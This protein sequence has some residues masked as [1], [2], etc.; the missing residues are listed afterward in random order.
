MDVNSLQPQYLFFSTEDPSKKPDGSNSVEYTLQPPQHSPSALHFVKELHLTYRT[1]DEPT[2]FFKRLE[3]VVVS[4][5]DRVLHRLSSSVWSTSI[6]LQQKNLMKNRKESQ[7]FLPLFSQGLIHDISL[8][9]VVVKVTFKN[10]MKEHDRV[11]LFVQYSTVPP[12]PFSIKYWTFTN[13]I[14][15]KMPTDE[16]TKEIDIAIPWG[17]NGLT[18]G[19]VVFHIPGANGWIQSGQILATD[20]ETEKDIVLYDFKDPYHCVVIDKVCF[21]TPL[22]KQPLFT[23]TF[24]NWH[25]EP[26]THGLLTN[27]T[28][29]LRLHLVLDDLPEDNRPE[30]ASLEMFAVVGMQRESK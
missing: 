5:G 3:E 25:K 27:N 22:P 7:L 4:Q 30:T 1:I 12:Y 21:D 20:P 28:H 13:S 19:Q 16:K 18:I 17:G 15:Q 8:K 2:D 10:Y 29:P 23:C 24:C 11:G 14:S 6:T 9:H 26:A